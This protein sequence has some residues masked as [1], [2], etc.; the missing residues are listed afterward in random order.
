MRSPFDIRSLHDWLKSMPADQSYDYTDSRRC[1]LCQYFDFIGLP[2][3]SVCS[4]GWFDVRGEKHP[5]PRDFLSVAVGM[6]DDTW[7]FG[8]AAKRAGMWVQRERNAATV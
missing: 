4:F 7:T 6:G 2:Y 5:L 3:E 1:V 8:Q